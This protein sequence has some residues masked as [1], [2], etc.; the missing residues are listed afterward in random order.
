MLRDI[1]T[2]PV[3]AFVLLRLLTDLLK[4]ASSLPA[5]SRDLIQVVLQAHLKEQKFFLA[6]PAVL[7]TEQH[8]HLFRRNFSIAQPAA[9]FDCICHCHKNADLELRIRTSA[10]VTSRAHDAQARARKVATWLAL[11]FSPSPS[12]PSPSRPAPCAP[13]FAPR[14]SQRAWGRG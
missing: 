2:S 4:K 8:G 7:L 12:R 5:F 6:I 11:F 13:P 10:V 3:V 14:P 1:P 9:G